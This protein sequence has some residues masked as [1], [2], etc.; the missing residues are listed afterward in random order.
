MPL[1]HQDSATDTRTNV[2][3]TKSSETVALTNETLPTT[4]WCV[5][6]AW[7]LLLLFALSLLFP[8]SV[9]PFAQTGVGPTALQ[10]EK[11]ES[12]PFPFLSTS[13]YRVVQ[14]APFPFLLTSICRIVLSAP[15]PVSVV[16]LP[17]LAGP[18]VECRR[19]LFSR[20]SYTPVFCT[21]RFQ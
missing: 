16:P 14:S 17:I 5:S 6:P 3:Q 21:I 4:R 15:L 8:L 20:C 18:R 1:A 9:H 7:S 13:I 10:R 11:L 2:P 12:A 19:L